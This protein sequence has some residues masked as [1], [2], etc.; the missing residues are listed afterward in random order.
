MA[1]DEKFL[2]KLKIWREKVDWK[3]ET[4]RYQFLLKLYPLI[5]R[6][7][8]QKLPDLRDIFRPEEIEW[9]IVEE[10]HRVDDSDLLVGELIPFVDF[11][12]KTGYKDIPEVDENGQP[13]SR[14]TT[15]VH[16]ASTGYIV[17]SF[18]PHRVVKR[19]WKRAF[20]VSS[21]CC[22]VEAAGLVPT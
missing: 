5:R 12:N 8:R 11:V 10:L 13:L 1:G 22:L 3:I 14:R 6:W 9:I 4:Q 20:K 21:R 16:C 19:R 15:P 17:R 2:N 7:W 18:V